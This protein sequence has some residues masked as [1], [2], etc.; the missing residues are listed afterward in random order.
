MVDY[1]L[2]KNLKQKTT[3]DQLVNFF[4]AYDDYKE[5]KILKSQLKL[6]R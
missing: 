3:Q 5:E 4:R 1:L 2:S 6:D